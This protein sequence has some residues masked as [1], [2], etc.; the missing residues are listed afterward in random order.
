[1]LAQR[2]F[3]VASGQYYLHNLRS[4]GFQTFDK[5]IDERYDTIENLEQRMQAVCN[6]VKSLDGRDPAIAAIA[7][8]NYHHL[9]NTDWT[10]IMIE[11][12]KQNLLRI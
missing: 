3:I 11:N 7:D 9:L 10:G 6:T 5:V 8:H 2:L 4:L 1:M 12:I